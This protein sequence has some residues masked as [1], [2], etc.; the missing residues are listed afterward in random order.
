[1]LIFSMGGRWGY[2]NVRFD[3]L[4]I[5]FT[6]LVVSAEFALE[7]VTMTRHEIMT[8]QISFFF[9]NMTVP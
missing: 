2:S 5:I 1:M 9:L 4:T 3:S 7:I 8:N 6:T